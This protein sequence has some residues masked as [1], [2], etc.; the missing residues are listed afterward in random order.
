MLTHPDLVRLFERAIDAELPTGYDCFYGV[1]D[2]RWRIWDLEHAVELLGFRPEDDAGAL[3]DGADGAT[4]STPAWR[5]PADL[6]LR[7]VRDLDDQQSPE[8]GNRLRHSLQTA[9]LAEQA[10][11]PPQWI[12]GALCHDVGSGYLGR[13]H[14]RIAANLLRPYVGPEVAWTLAVHDDFVARSARAGT[15]AARRHAHLRH[16]AHPHYRAAQRFADEWDVPAVPSGPLP[17][18]LE[19]FEPML[20]R[21]VSKPRPGASR[22]RRALDVALRPLP[23]RLSGPIDR[24]ARVAGARLRR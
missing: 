18:P 11:A 23:A 12:V 3:D 1:S 13:G 16:L 2:N 21:V 19:H 7:M 24:Q 8:T 15:G 17:R 14:G 22:R 4:R 20:R 9:T 5:D 10:G 6:L